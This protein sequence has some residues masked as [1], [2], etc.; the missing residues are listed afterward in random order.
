MAIQP[1]TMKDVGPRE[2]VAE[3]RKPVEQDAGPCHPEQSEGSLQLLVN[4]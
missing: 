4:H 1:V 2:K 3:A